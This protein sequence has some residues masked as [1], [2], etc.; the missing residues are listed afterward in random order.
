[1]IIARAPYRVSFFGGG[2]DYP[3]WYETHGGACF[4][5][6]IDHYCHVLVR[7][8]PPFLG[9]K[10]R[11]FY[12]QTELV[13]EIEDI[14][15][16]GIR[17]CLEYFRRLGHDV[18]QIEINHAG[19]LPARSGLGS[20]SSFSVALCCAL[21]RLCG[22]SSTSSPPEIA[23]MAIDVEQNILGETVG[24]QDQIAASCGGAM[25]I[26]ILPDAP[27]RQ[28]WHVT[29][30]ALPREFTDHFVLVFTGLQRFAADIAQTQIDRMEENKE[31]LRWIQASV[32]KGIELA[33][34]ADMEGFGELLQTA[35]EMKRS[36]SPNV[37]TPEID[38]MIERGLKAGA[39]GAKVLGAG[40]GGFVL[41]CCAPEDRVRVAAASAAKDSP[42]AIPLTISKSGGRVIWDSEAA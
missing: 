31:A 28:L 12:Q 24:I 32:E 8:M 16:A 23:R 20:S 41:F 39:Y 18:S 6:A 36:L 21:Q 40:G 19:D 35:W 34:R 25:H 30:V 10:Y 2:T 4:S 29:P 9:S 7:R 42:L 3:A 14:K 33:C 37:S 5:V 1:M 17:G 13:D 11:L 27:G 15:H 38:Y 26:Q 22:G